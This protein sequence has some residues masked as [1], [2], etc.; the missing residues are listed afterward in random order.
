M[1][2][3]IIYTGKNESFI[4]NESAGVPAASSASLRPDQVRRRRL[5]VDRHS[6]GDGVCVPKLPSHIRIQ[7]FWAGGMCVNTCVLIC[8]H[9][10]GGLHT[11]GWAACL[12]CRLYQRLQPTETKSLAL[13]YARAG[14]TSDTS[15]S[16]QFQSHFWGCC[17]SVPVS[18]SGGETVF[19]KCFP[20]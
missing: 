15:R 8:T 3:S 17:T 14:K 1:Q 19:M 10:E 6:R 5:C 2:S 18:D 13:S 9:G 7:S 16:V 20:L 12:H 4:N 11:Q